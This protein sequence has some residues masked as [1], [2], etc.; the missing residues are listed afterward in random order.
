V[1]ILKEIADH[2]VAGD[3][4][5]VSR[6]IN[7]ALKGGLEPRLVMDGGLIAGMSV[8]GERFK[9]NEIYLPDVLV[10]ARAMNAGL[11]LLEPLLA[12]S[13]RE[14]RARVV[15][16][17]VKGDLHDIGK[18]MVV[19]MLRGAGFQVTD[20]GVDVAPER[21]LEALRETGA[22]LLTMSSLL[23]LSMPAMEA[24]VEV[25]R[26]SELRDQ[27]KI[28]VGGAPVTRRYADSIGADGYAPD[29]AVAVEEAKGLLDEPEG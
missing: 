20:L 1:E 22:R 18:N 4:D 3:A 26:D 19:M 2:L 29:S 16:G 21:F 24:T 13:G 6:G 11:T 15:S 8:I 10:S 14:R 12:E 27:V 17:T 7:A 5:E 9:N 25:V 23:T 28:M